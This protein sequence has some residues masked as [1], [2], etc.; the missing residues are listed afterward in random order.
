MPLPSAPARSCSSGGRPA[1]SARGGRSRGTARRSRWSGAGAAG[2]ADGLSGVKLVIS[3]SHQGLKLAI[4]AVLPGAAWQRCRMHA[5]RN[6]LTRVPKAA[7]HLVATLVRSIFAQPER[8]Q[9]WAQHGRVVVQLQQRFP[10]AAAMLAEAEPELLAFADF[11]KEHWRQIWS[12]HPQER[13]NQEVRR[14]T[15]VV[16]I[17]PHRQAV[18]RLVSAVLA[19]PHDEW[20]VTRRYLSP[21][22]LTQAQMAVVDGSPTQPKAEEVMPALADA[23]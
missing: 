13:L 3:D 16:G 15:D 21:E 23:S 22:S 4:A 8:A 17:F 7:Q 2:S 6:L 20:A 9:V 18:L 14:R 1:G 10:Q 12:N 19:E 5:L 11:P